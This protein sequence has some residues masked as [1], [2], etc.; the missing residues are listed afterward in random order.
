MFDFID[1]IIM[2]DI[3]DKDKLIAS[4]QNQVRG[5]SSKCSALEQEN[6][7]LNNELENLKKQP[8]KKVN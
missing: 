6:A 1:C 7:L 2:N 4:L 3:L 8:K 5:L